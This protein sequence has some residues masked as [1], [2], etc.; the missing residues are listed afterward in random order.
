MRRRDF[1]RS[2]SSAALV[3][4]VGAAPSARASSSRRTAVVIG[5]GIAGLSAAWELRKSGFDVRIFEKWEFVG[6][7]MRDAWM[8][9][10]WGPPHA[11]GISEDNREMFAL[12][13]ELGISADLAGDTGSDE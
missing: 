7:R 8:G 1:I 5:A 3:S 12:G 10:I 13:D 2:V 9:P 11:L 4:G 6:G